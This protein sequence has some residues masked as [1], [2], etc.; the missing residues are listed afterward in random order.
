[1]EILVGGQEDVQTTVVCLEM[2][3]VYL[4]VMWTPSDGSQSLC[5]G[6]GLL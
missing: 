4:E 5:R 2:H 1:V 3:V 6:A